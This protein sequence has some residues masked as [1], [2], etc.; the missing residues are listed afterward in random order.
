MVGFRAIG[1]RE[2]CELL[3]LTVATAGAAQRLGRLARPGPLAAKVPGIVAALLIALA[4][5]C[6]NEMHITPPPP[7]TNSS[8]F[9]D[10]GNADPRPV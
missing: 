7:P 2:D 9:G 10:F 3:K 8:N 6:T 4:A 1:K 5:A